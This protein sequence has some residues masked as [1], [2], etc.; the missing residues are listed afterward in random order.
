MK[1]LIVDDSKT[2]RNFLS[3]IVRGLAIEVEQAADGEEALR[4]IA[5]SGPF[6]LAMVDWTMP[7]MDGISLVRRIRAKPE[8]NQLKLMMVTARNEREAVIEAV[9]SGADDFLMKPMTAEMVED[10]LRILGLVA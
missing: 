1:V 9:C 2:M 10:K 5:E 4:C 8:W 7:G 6:D 3:A